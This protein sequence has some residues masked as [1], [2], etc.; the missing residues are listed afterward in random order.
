MQALNVEAASP[1]RAMVARAII[2]LVE[3]GE[4]AMDRLAATA[5]EEMRGAK[6]L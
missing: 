2:L 5:V 1:A 6:R 4:T 3:E